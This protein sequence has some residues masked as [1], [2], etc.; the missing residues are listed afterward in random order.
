MFDNDVVSEAEEHIRNTA[1]R[2]GVKRGYIKDPRGAH[3]WDT[4]DY[5]AVPKCDSCRRSMRENARILNRENIDS[6]RAAIPEIDVYAW[7]PG[8]NLF[9]WWCDAENCASETARHW[10]NR[11]HGT[12]TK[13]R[14]SDIEQIP[15]TVLQKFGIPIRYA[16][17]TLGNFHENPKVTAKFRDYISAPEKSLFITGGCGSGKTHIAVAILREL[18]LKGRTNLHFAVVTDLLLEITGLIRDE[19]AEESQSALIDRMAYY[20]ILVLDDLGAE[21]HTD[22]AVTTL[23]TLI[24]RRLNFYKRT[25]I[26][27]NLTLDG[28]R[29][30]LSDRIASRLSEYEII[31]FTMPDWRKKR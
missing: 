31:K 15:E 19:N 8:D 29:D 22:F 16:H 10:R 27:S 3:P 7:R 13:Q 30:R 6:I 24:N 21:K 20:D 11:S 5:Y 17:C 1:G 25:I 9:W 23:Y 2:P 12:A 4:D 26:T 14:E 18:Y 28:V